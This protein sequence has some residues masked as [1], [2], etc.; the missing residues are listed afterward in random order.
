MLII[1]QYLRGVSDEE[2]AKVDPNNL[3]SVRKIKAFADAIDSGEYFEMPLI[4]REEMTK[5]KGAFKELG[6]KWNI[7][8][9]TKDNFDELLDSRELSPYDVSNIDASSMGF[10]EMYDVYGKQ[11]R[12]T[13][14]RMLEERPVNYYEYNLD[15]IAHRVAFNKIRKNTFDLIMPTI[16]AYMWW[17]K[18]IGAKQNIDVSK[19]LEYVTNQIKLAIFNEPII[20]DEQATIAKG[21]SFARQIS[22]V[23]MLAFRPVL[24]AKEL[25][26]GVLRNL[27]AA[28]VN[29]AQD[30]GAKEMTEAYGKLITIDNKFTD[31]FNLIDKMNFFY[32][33]ANMDISTVPKKIQTDR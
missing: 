14:A 9:M 3:E 8:G 22:S 26:V 13:K 18:L 23:A 17:I 21:L 32:G 16:N 1:N 24:L 19:Q 2:V 20:G 31:E 30:F 25:T 4:R 6:E 5:Y 7:F 12:E 27:S 10:Y 11:D 28:G 29:Y 15:T 33:M